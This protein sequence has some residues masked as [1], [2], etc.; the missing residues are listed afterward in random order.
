MYVLLT[1]I[2]CFYLPHTLNWTM[3][4]DQC[5]FRSSKPKNL[6]LKRV[7]NLSERRRSPKNTRIRLSWKSDTQPTL[8][9]IQQKMAKIVTNELTSLQNV[10]IFLGMIMPTYVRKNLAKEETHLFGWDEPWFYEFYVLTFVTPINFL[11]NSIP[12]CCC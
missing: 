4:D 3:T 8:K 1:I 5:V 2:I 9:L 6:S 12:H 10:H 7:S 11:K